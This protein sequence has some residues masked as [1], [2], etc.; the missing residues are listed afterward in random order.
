MLNN[1]MQHMLQ[2]MPK[3][4]YTTDISHLTFYVFLVFWAIFLMIRKLVLNM[5]GVH[6][7]TSISNFLNDSFG[8]TN[9]I[10]FIKLIE[11]K[12]HKSCK[13]GQTQLRQICDVG[14]TKHGQLIINM[15][16]LI[17]FYVLDFLISV[18]I[19]CNFVYKFMIIQNPIHFPLSFSLLHGTLSQQGRV[20]VIVEWLLEIINQNM[21]CHLWL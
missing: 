2:H 20:W 7:V 6:D 18:I 3:C 16:L 19:I 13:T 5:E 4:Q 10:N 9:L 8:F 11:N 21:V 12:I 14:Q 15:R 17:I 1:P